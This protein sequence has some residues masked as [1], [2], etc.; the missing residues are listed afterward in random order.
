[1]L[2]KAFGHEIDSTLIL[3]KT[4][5]RVEKKDR[6]DHAKRLVMI[7]KRSL[8]MAEGAYETARLADELEEAFRAGRN[9]K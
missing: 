9:A 7:A 1:M 3:T 2:I 5:D 8:Q 4:S 6:A